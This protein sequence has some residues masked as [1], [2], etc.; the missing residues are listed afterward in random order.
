MVGLFQAEAFYNSMT[1]EKFEAAKADPDTEVL[2]ALLTYET[3]EGRTTLMKACMNENVALVKALI[4]AGA[5]V[6]AASEEGEQ[7]L[8]WAML[9]SPHPLK[10]EE[11]Q[12]QI[13]KML[14]EAGAELGPG[15]GCYPERVA[16]Y[17]PASVG[18]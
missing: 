8:N 11:P 12:E 16:Q 1:L 14:V 3:D 18:A 17:R 9:S 5:D 4:E 7:V 2:Q 6:N 13:V 15:Y 10:P